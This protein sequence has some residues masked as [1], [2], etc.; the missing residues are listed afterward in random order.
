MPVCLSSV[1]DM[2]LLPLKIPTVTLLHLCGDQGLKGTHYLAMKITWLHKT[3]K[4]QSRGPLFSATRTNFKF[5]ALMNH[6]LHFD[7]AQSF[8][9]FPWSFWMSRWHQETLN[10]PRLPLDSAENEVT[11]YGKH[12]R[13]QASMGVV[14]TAI[15]IGREFVWN[16]NTNLAVCWWLT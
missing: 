16:S 2:T 11:V 1:P 9:Y 7:R 10:H 4:D 12:G 6:R 13:R 15:A 5:T 3:E 14:H 8:I